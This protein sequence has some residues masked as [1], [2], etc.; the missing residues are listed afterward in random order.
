MGTVGRACRADRIIGG[1]PVAMRGLV[2][3][4]LGAQVTVVD[5]DGAGRRC[6]DADRLVPSKTLIATSGMMAR[7]WAGSAAHGIRS[8]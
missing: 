5:R 3:A 2:S 1:G 6:V 4:Q 7:W 8:G